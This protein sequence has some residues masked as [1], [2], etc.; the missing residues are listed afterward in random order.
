MMPT[1]FWLTPASI[2]RLVTL[3]LHQQLKTDQEF[4]LG[5]RHLK[6]LRLSGEARNIILRDFQQLPR[7]RNLIYREW[8]KW[9]KGTDPLLSITF[10]ADCRRDHPEVTY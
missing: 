7:E 5:E 1:S 10:E 9:L 4:I 2:Q 8:E 3:Y 6:T